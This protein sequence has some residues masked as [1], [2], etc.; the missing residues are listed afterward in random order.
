MPFP[1][2]KVVKM[3]K[4]SDRKVLFVFQNEI[5]KQEIRMY[6]DGEWEKIRFPKSLVIDEE[7]LNGN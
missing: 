2:W 6:R 5:G 7:D 1:M 3:E 4:Y